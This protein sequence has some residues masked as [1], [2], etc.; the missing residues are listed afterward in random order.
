MTDGC[1]H[2]R[3]VMYCLSSH[4]TTKHVIIMLSDFPIMFSSTEKVETFTMDCSSTL[5]K[6][7]S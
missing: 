5:M 1:G 7:V 4:Q 3:P 6:G 2:G